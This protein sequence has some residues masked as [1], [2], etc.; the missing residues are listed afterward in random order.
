[1][2]ENNST[3]NILDYTYKINISGILSTVSIMILVGLAISVMPLLLNNDQTI[4]YTSQ[5]LYLAVILLFVTMMYFDWWGLLVGVLTFLVC[6]WVLDLKTGIL[7]SNTLAN[8]LQ[9]ILLHLSGCKICIYLVSNK[10][11][12]GSLCKY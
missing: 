3:K 9:L 10:V 8:I 4:F 12:V 1:M 5:S 11:T 7:I 6:G 2:R